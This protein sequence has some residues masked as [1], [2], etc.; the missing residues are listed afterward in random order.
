MWLP[1]GMTPS[2][3]SALGDMAPKYTLEQFMESELLINLTEHMLVPEHVVM[4]DEEK[5]ELLARW[6][7]IF[8]FLE[9]LRP[10]VLTIQL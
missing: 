10:N 8:R 6:N 3:K 7:S 9:K 1:G 2:A 5:K 4:T